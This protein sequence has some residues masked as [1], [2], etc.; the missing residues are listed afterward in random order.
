MQADWDKKV[1]AHL[2]KLVKRHQW[3]RKVSRY[4]VKIL[5]DTADGALRSKGEKRV[6]GSIPRAMVNSLTR[7]MDEGVK[8]RKGEV[9]V[10]LVLERI[11]ASMNVMQAVRF[12][13][14]VFL[15]NGTEGA[16]LRRLV[17]EVRIGSCTSPVFS[18]FLIQEEE[19]IV[20]WAEWTQGQLVM[21]KTSLGGDG[22]VAV[23][24]RGKKDAE[25]P[26]GY[27]LMDCMGRN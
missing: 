4:D 2:N 26:F 8:K 24:T 6:A 23:V 3:L 12:G 5:W 16:G 15:H 22:G 7:M 21:G 18:S 25:F 11:L 10:A 17:K 27:T 19:G 1:E 9:Q 13:L 20:E 14:D